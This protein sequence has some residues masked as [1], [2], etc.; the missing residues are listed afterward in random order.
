M[1]APLETL[2]LTRRDVAALLDIDACITAVEAA[3]RVHGQGLAPPPAIAGLH[4]PHGGFHVKA[5]TLA[6]VPGRPYVAAKI[7]ANMPGNR[8]RHGLPT[9][10]GAIVLLDGDSG[11]VLALLDS[12]EITV[13]RTAA[14]TA[15]AAKYLAR[16]AAAVVAVCGCGL[17]GAAQLRAFT[18]VRPVSRVLAW[19]LDPE[20]ARAYAGAQSAALNLPVQAVA[21]SAEAVRPSDVV[22][23]CTTA[24]RWFVGREDVQPG[25]FIAAVGA[26]NERKQEIEPALL[27]RSTVV[28]DVLTQAA[29]IGD[30]H[31][32]IAAG[33]MTSA[34]V[35]AELGEV[36]AGRKPGR[37][38]DDEVIVFDSTGTALQDVAAAAVVYERAVAAGAGTRVPLAGS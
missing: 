3:F 25:S 24:T 26:D 34:D 35:H 38:S 31:H 19:D 5:A 9:I 8:E 28:A 2:V 16:P 22:L 27:A 29:T 4:A 6:L 17:Q 21:T 32:A 30:L 37:Q 7:N 12:V 11:R 36:V 33:L 23:T 20:R 15:V 13:L 10:Q 14:A 1:P 18:R